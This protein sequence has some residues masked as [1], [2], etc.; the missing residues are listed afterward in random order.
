MT[1]IQGKAIIHGAMLEIFNTPNLLSQKTTRSLAEV[2]PLQFRHP[3]QFNW[4][5]PNQMGM[6]STK[7]HGGGNDAVNVHQLALDASKEKWTAGSWFVL[8]PNLMLVLTN[9]IH[10]SLS[11]STITSLTFRLGLLID[12]MELSKEK[13]S[14]FR[15]NKCEIYQFI[16]SKMEH[17]FNLF[18]M[19]KR[20]EEITEDNDNMI[21]NILMNYIA[22]VIVDTLLDTLAKVLKETKA[23]GK[24]L[25]E[26]INEHFNRLHNLL[27]DIEIDN[28]IAND[29][30]DSYFNWIVVGVLHSAKNGDLQNYL[31]HLNLQTSVSHESQN[32]LGPGR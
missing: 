11:T 2:V 7:N 24:A 28:L 12:K 17:L 31:E 5:D 32:N 16:I 21:I 8:L 3:T 18:V 14:Y 29:T 27:A 19:C 1:E 10:P 13:K 9:N 26:S 22:D 4:R 30:D 20:Y 6:Y 23:D 25:C 15:R